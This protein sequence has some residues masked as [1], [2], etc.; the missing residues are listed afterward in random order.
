M[1]TDQ[2]ADLFQDAL[3]E[4]VANASPAQ[5]VE[6]ESKVFRLL[7]RAAHR[8]L[9]AIRDDL[10]ALA[11]LKPAESR[12][13]ASIPLRIPEVLDQM[14]VVPGEHKISRLLARNTPHEDFEDVLG[15]G[16]HALISTPIACPHETRRTLA[17]HNLAESGAMF[18]LPMTIPSA[19]KLDAQGFCSYAIT[20]QFLPTPFGKR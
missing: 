3:S 11:V 13:D 7:L 6:V 4:D 14:S 16:D 10:F 8:A 12:A 15:H 1:P 2:H 18:K 17:E 20:W 19:R 9:S 5:I